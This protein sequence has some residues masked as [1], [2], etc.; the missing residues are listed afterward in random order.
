MEALIKRLEE[1]HVK[2]DVPVGNRITAPEKKQQI[3]HYNL[4][5]EELDEFKEACEKDDIVGIADGLGD[6]LFVLL[7]SVVSHGLQGCFREIIEEVCASNM[8][9]LGE[10]GKP[11]Y[12][13]DGKLMRGSNYF[14]PNLSGIIEKHIQREQI[15]DQL[16]GK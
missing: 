10:D 12:R 13:A 8:S 15:K 5:R 4:M 7:S 6:V 14:P 9:K 2:F 11:I 16:E 3:L 1:W